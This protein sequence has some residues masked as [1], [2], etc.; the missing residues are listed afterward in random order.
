MAP[1][2]LSL[3]VLACLAGVPASAETGIRLCDETPVAKLTLEQLRDCQ[4]FLKAAD[5]IKTLL[6]RPE[7][8]RS[9]AILVYR[10]PTDHPEIVS[11]V[12]K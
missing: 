8:P 9:C 5:H 1:R 6:A 12:C 2:I 10:G 4:S 3:A 11:K 7:K